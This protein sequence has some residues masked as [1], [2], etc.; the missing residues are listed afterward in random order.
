MKITKRQIRRI[1][2]ESLN[3]QI[4]S[5]AQIRDLEI[6]DNRGAFQ[7]MLDSR[8]YPLSFR[9]DRE[10]GY[11]GYPVYTVQGDIAVLKDWF[12]NWYSQGDPGAASDFD[13]FVE[14]I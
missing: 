4:G 5:K 14:L 10:E 12:I 11:S 9:L 3:E 6:V 2:R 13:E 8:K 1:I 7:A